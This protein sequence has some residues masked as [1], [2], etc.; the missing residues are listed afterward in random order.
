M[1]PQ[2]QQRNN[3]RKGKKFEDKVQKTIGSGKVW[4][5][6]LDLR[7]DKYCIEAKFTDKKGY[8]ISRELLDKIWD[9]ALSMN[10]EPFLIIGIKRNDNQNFVLHCHINIERRE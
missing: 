6:P 7:Y 1:K 5:S 4:F 2:R 10:K 3:Q 8:R 9:S